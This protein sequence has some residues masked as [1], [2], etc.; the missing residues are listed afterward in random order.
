[1]SAHA[2]P[3]LSGAISS[4]ELFMS[5]WEKLGENFNNLKPLTDIGLKWAKKYYNRMDDTWAY[6]IAMCKSFFFSYLCIFLTY[7]TL[8]INPCIHFSWIKREWNNNFIRHAKKVILET[9][10]IINSITNCFKFC[11]IN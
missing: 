6:I 11:V 8:V 4:F 3:V 7:S 2:T 10:H 9:V 1:M 5:K